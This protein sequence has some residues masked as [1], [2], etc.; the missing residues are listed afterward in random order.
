MKFEANWVKVR[1]WIQS[2]L[3]RTHFLLPVGGAITLIT[4][5]HIYAISIIHRTNHWSVIKIRQ[6]MWTLLDTSCISILR[7]SGL[8]PKYSCKQRWRAQAECKRHPGGI[9]KTVPRE[10]ACRIFFFRCL[11]K[12]ILN[13]Y[14]VSHNVFPVHPHS[15]KWKCVI[16]RS[17]DKLYVIPLPNNIERD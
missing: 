5:S 7:L 15:L 14:L 13:I 17:K 8:G 1:C 6:C 16:I 12:Y 3:K 2:I 10:R 4:N 9:R 11:A